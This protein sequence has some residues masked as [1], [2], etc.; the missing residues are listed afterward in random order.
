LILSKH[1]DATRQAHTRHPST[2]FRLCSKTQPCLAQTKQGFF[3]PSNLS[4]KRIYRIRRTYRARRR[5]YRPT[6]QN[7]SSSQIKER[8]PWFFDP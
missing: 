5:I 3:V 4:A 7:P 2:P 1:Q 8:G 6:L